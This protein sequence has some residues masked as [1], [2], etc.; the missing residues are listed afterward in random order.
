MFWYSI[1]S[2]GKL[3]RVDAYAV[4]YATLLRSGAKYGAWSLQSSS[5]V[6]PIHC[7]NC[8]EL[9]ACCSFRM[10]GVQVTEVDV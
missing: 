7:P 8:T 6:A 9:V 3:L 5:S 1:S 10:E 2:C 4:V